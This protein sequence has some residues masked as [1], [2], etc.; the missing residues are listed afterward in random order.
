MILFFSWRYGGWVSLFC[1]ILFYVLTVDMIGIV[2]FS[3][4][5]RVVIT[6][7]D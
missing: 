4:A 5:S 6:K 2:T 7:L 1:A 3:V